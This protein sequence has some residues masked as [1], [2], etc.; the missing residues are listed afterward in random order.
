MQYGDISLISVSFHPRKEKF[1]FIVINIQSVFFGTLHR[2]SEKEEGSFLGFYI[3]ETFSH[4]VNSDFPHFKTAS[5]SIL[6]ERFFIW[7]TA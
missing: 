4:P 2:R 1:S 5:L 7:L 6:T 3:A